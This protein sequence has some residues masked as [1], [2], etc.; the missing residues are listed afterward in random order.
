MLGDNGAASRNRTC[1]GGLFFFLLLSKLICYEFL[2]STVLPLDDCRI[3]AG[4]YC[5]SLPSISLN[6][7][8][9]RTLRE[10]RL[11]DL[12]WMSSLHPLP[13]YHSV[14][15][16]HYIRLKWITPYNYAC[17]PA[18]F[19]AVRQG[20]LHPYGVRSGTWTHDLGFIRPFEYCCVCFRTESHFTCSDQLSYPDICCGWKDSNLQQSVPFL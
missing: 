11:S 9:R 1:G 16:F 20:Y 13:L 3:E 15:P 2:I 6:I 18:V 14:T 17:W 4:R 19:S 5:K 12:F 7:F 10:N 8:A